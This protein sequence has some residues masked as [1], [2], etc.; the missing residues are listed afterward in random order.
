MSDEIKI[1]TNVGSANELLYSSNLNNGQYWIARNADPGFITIPGV[2]NPVPVNFPLIEDPLGG[3][4]AFSM[5]SDTYGMLTGYKYTIDNSESYTYETIVGVGTNL[6]SFPYGGN[7][8]SYYPLVDFEDGEIF[9]FF[10]TEMTNIYIS[11]DGILRFNIY[12]ISQPDREIPVENVFPILDSLGSLRSI[13]LPYWRDLGISSGGIWYQQLTDRIIIEYNNIAGSFGS[14]NPTQTFQIHLFFDPINKIEIRYKN[15]SK[16]GDFNP[17]PLIGIQSS[18]N[19]YEYY[20]Y[21]LAIIDRTKILRFSPESYDIPD[22]CNVIYFEAPEQNAFRTF[23]IYLKRIIGSGPISYTLN[24]GLTWNIIPNFP[25]DDNTS[26]YLYQFPSTVGNQQIGIQISTYGAYGDKIGLYA[27]Q[28]EPLDFASERIMTFATPVV[29]EEQ[30]IIVDK[31]VFP[32]A[33]I[34]AN[35]ANNMINGNNCLIS[36]T[37]DIVSNIQTSIKYTVNCNRSPV[38]NLKQI[39]PTNFLLDSIEKQMDITSTNLPNFIDFS[40]NK[41]SGD[42]SITLKDS[43]NVIS[44]ILKMSSGS[45]VSSQQMGVQEGD[46]LITQASIKEIVV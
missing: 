7:L 39:N 45:Y 30:F 8:S 40:G 33:D 26:W 10:G 34:S 32:P 44:S 27:P 29:R 6:I 3:T 13:I 24:G 36:S 4:D 1:I 25:T 15:V 31:N 37:T 22:L 5:Q 42:L 41:L 35:F 17:N 9:K 16:S 11:N 2:P 14:T 38:Y 21:D 46:T 20:A 43:S 19:E 12:D 28:L 23:S 18:D